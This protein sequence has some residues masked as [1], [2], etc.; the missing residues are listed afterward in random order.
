MTTAVG[1]AT[2]GLSICYDLRFARLYDALALA[3]ADV[4]TVP[5]AFSATTG[6]KHWHTLLRARA[7]ETGSF[8]VAAAQSGCHENGRETYGH[9][10]IV[11]PDGTVLAERAEGEDVLVADLDLGEVKAA[12]RRLPTLANRALDAVLEAPA[13][14]A[15]A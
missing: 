14:S 2:L 9:S 10:L 1:P 3:G 7:I 4:L 15:A 6:A 8:V 13:R 12:R 5:A 11:S